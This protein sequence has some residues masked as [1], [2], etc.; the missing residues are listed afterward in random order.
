MKR[1]QIIVESQYNI[2]VQPVDAEA[3]EYPAEM[4]VEVQILAT[5]RHKSVTLIGKNNDHVVINP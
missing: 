5:L 1:I 4:F 3:Y 2:M